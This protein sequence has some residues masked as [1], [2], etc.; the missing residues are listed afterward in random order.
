MEK[1][2]QTRMRI[3]FGTIELGDHQPTDRWLGNLQRYPSVRFFGLT[4]GR[5]FFGLILGAKGK[6]KLE[7]TQDELIRVEDEL[8]VARR[9]I[10]TLEALETKPV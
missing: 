4:R 10:T 7:L 9:K 2:P 6:S 8:A 1:D 5:A 3:H